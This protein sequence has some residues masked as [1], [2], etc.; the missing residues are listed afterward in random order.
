M[1]V[2]FCVL[3]VYVTSYIKSQLACP[4]LLSSIPGFFAES[5]SEDD[6]RVICDCSGDATDFVVFTAGALGMDEMQMCR[7][8]AVMK[9]VMVMM[10]GD[11][12]DDDANGRVSCC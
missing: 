8:L 3:C 4:R 6:D 12:Q 10:P 11:K 1:S 7:I 9:M 2:D 5:V